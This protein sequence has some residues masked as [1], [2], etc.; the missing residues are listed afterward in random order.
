MWYVFHH[1][2]WGK[3]EEVSE[4]TWYGRR[5][6]GSFVVSWYVMVGTALLGDVEGGK[7]P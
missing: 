4:L 6:V 3:E 1:R 5:D 7:E 2:I